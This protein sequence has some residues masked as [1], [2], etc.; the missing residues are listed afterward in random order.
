M[1]WG[2]H[3]ISSHSQGGERINTEEDT[4]DRTRQT[5]QDVADARDL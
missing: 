4:K 5:L 1:T 3:H 2:L